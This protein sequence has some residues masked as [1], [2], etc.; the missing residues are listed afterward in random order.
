MTYISLRSNDAKK[1]AKAEALET[2]L[3][4]FC[5]TQ[6]DVDLDIFLTN[7]LTIKPALIAEGIDTFA[8]FHTLLYDNQCNTEFSPKIIA[9]VNKI[10][11]TFCISADKIKVPKKTL[12]NG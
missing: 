5:S 12:K 8:I 4:R 3:D 10:G 9:L 7:F 11:A 1:E 2:E 6:I